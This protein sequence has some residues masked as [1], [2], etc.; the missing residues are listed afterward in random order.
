MTQAIKELA[1]ET[2]IVAAQD[3]CIA[4][5][6]GKKEI[7]K[8]LNSPWMDFFTDGVSKVVA[9][10]LQTNEQEISERLKSDVE[11]KRRN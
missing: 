4:G 11:M 1:A 5:P 2:L 7:I 8:E 3:Y 9:Q 6:N 10:A